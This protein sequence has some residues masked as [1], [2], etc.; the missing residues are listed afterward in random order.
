MLQRLSYASETSEDM[1]QQ[2]RVSTDPLVRELVERLAAA[3][4]QQ[5]EELV[6]VTAELDELQT[7]YDQLNDCKNREQAATEDE[8]EQQL[9]TLRENTMDSTDIETRLRRIED[10]L[11]N[12]VE[13]SALAGTAPQSEPEPTIDDLRTALMALRDTHGKTA[14]Y[15]IVEQFATGKPTLGNIAT[16]RFTRVLRACAEAQQVAA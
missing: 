15:D 3:L 7:E 1:V 10:L 13:A 8:Y 14:A 2:H 4:D 11:T 9:N 5:D 6:R 12:I 16:D